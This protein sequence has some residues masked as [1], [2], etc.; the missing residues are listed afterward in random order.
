MPF[1]N[2]RVEEDIKRE[3]SDLLGVR[4]GEIGQ[5]PADSSISQPALHFIAQVE[6]QDEARH[7]DITVIMTEPDRKFKLTGWIEIQKG[8]GMPDKIP[9]NEEFNSHPSYLAKAIRRYLNKYKVS[10][11]RSLNPLKGYFG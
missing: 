7:Y 10:R 4:P 5:Q 1:V 6:L 9:I 2:D 11:K 3:I 8:T